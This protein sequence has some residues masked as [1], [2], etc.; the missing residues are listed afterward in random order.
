[1]RRDP[2]YDREGLC[3]ALRR[4]KQKEAGGKIPGAKDWW[5]EPQLAEHVAELKRAGKW[6][7]A[8]P[9]VVMDFEVQRA[10]RERARVEA[11]QI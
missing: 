3:E 6:A 7:P 11:N 8:P 5:D 9:P 10:A 2:R 4:R 1:V